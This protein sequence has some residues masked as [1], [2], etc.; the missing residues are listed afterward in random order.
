ME[1]INTYLIK[2]IDS[3]PYDLEGTVE[4]L[5]YAYSMD[6]KSPMT[7]CLMGRVQA[8]V[9]KNYELAKAYYSEAI[10]IDVYAFDVYFYYADVLMINED[11]DEAKRLIDFALT[12]KGIEKGRLHLKRAILQE[13]RKAYNQ[14]LKTLKEAKK[15][16]YSE[17]LMDDIQSIKARI[18]SK[19]PKKKKVKKDDNKAK[20][21]IKK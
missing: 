9:F 21:E 2:A 10:S 14:A 11:F 13:Y 20:N 19:M 8:D 16:A 18:K 5:Q 1:Q 15:N 6:D 7:L 17:Y 4:A 3:Y 12:L